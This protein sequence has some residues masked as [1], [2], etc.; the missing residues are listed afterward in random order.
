VITA[1][2]TSGVV[3]GV[4]RREPTATATTIVTSSTLAAKSTSVEVRHAL[5]AVNSFAVRSARSD[6]RRI[7]VSPG[8]NFAPVLRT[9]GY[10]LSRVLPHGAAN[11]QVRLTV[12]R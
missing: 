12:E 5:S 2:A 7:G 1:W 9:S 8:R 4:A 3:S 10:R 11:E 6:A